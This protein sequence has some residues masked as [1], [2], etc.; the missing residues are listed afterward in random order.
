MKETKNQI[1]LSAITIWG[2]NLAATLDDIA[3]HTGISRRTLHRHYSGRDDLMY[4][5]FNFI[6]DEYLTQ[7]NL[8]IQN[9]PCDIE[10]LKA[11]LQFDIFSSKKYL[12]FCQLRKVEFTDIETENENFK[13]MYSKYVDLFKRLQDEQKISKDLSLQWVEIFYLAVVE[14]SDKMMDSGVSKEDCFKMAWW[15][16]WNGI[17]SDN[18]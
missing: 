6:I 10:K 17:K 13:E 7:L 15:S 12:V 1:L 4:S 3:S 2:K 18:Q 5:V 9:T 11:F 8:T 16:L 14:A